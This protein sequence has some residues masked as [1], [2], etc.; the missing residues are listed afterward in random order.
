MQSENRSLNSNCNLLR[1]RIS[2]YRYTCFVTN[3][4]LPMKV[5]YDTYDT[6]EAVLTLR[7]V[8][9]ILNTISPSTSLPPITFGRRRLVLT[10]SQ[11]GQ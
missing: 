4:T 10:L 11:I 7:I 5:V 1:W 8:S 9:R 6:I 2:S 3:I